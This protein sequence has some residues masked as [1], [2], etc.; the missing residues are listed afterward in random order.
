[1]EDLLELDRTRVWHPYGPMPSSTPPLPVVSASGVRL[2]LAD[3]RELVDGMASWWCAIHGYRHPV[4]DRAVTDQLQRMA[5]VMFGGLTH[6]PAVRLAER[7]TDW[8]GLDHVFFA[9][10]GSVSVEVAIKLVLQAWH[11]ERTK[12]LT[13]RGGYHGDTFG[14]MAVCDPDGGMHSMWRGVLPEHVFAPLPRWD[15]EWVAATRRL[16]EEH[17]LAG[18]IVEPIVQGAG[19]MRFHPRECVQLLRDLC[20]EHGIFLILDE[21]AT[22][23]GRTGTLFAAADLAD[24]L[25]LGKALTGGYMTLAATLCTAAVA[26]RLHG[27]LMHGPTFMAN[28]LATAAALAST[29]LLENGSWRQDVARIEAGLRA[30]LEDAP[31]DVRVKG[32]IGVIELDHDVD[33]PRATQAAVEAGVWLRPFRNLIYAMPPYVTED[34]DVARIAAA[35]VNACASS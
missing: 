16:F 21:I 26:E 31:G 25:C 19:G 12:L 28:P 15:A 8:T 9:D 23:F 7:L 18:V 34:E 3:G 6:E 24:V 1:V 5:H 33:V 4:L 13:W 30:G 14:A 32:A 35:M 29:G 20:D 22:G 17:T 11:G 27:P 2:K 10:S